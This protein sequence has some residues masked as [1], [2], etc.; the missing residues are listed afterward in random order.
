MGVY[1]ER[2]IGFTSGT[3][4][5]FVVPAGRRAI[6]KMVTAN[7]ATAA[8]IQAVVQIAGVAVCVL[9]VPVNDGRSVL[10]M[11]AVAYEGESIRAVLSSAPGS[12]SV[13]G[14]LLAG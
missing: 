8:A 11:H 4:R 5:T 7:N 6:V 2:L 9:S 1:S 12:M 10:G 3:E 13:H 14:Y